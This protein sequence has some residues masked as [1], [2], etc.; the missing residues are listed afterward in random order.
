M[1]LA[2]PDFTL[3]YV[4]EHLTELP[5][6]PKVVQKALAMLED[7]NTL[8]TDLA[9]VL[10]FDPSITANILKVTNSAHFG[11][12][13][14][15]TSLETALALLG[16]KQIRE[17]LVA[18]ASLPYL[19][20]PIRGYGMEPRDLWAHSI[21]CALAS[22]M[23]AEYINFP[24]TDVLFTSALLH[25]IGKIVLNIFV[26]ARLDEIQAV[27]RQEDITFS[28][29]EW[30]VIG[31]DHAVLGSQLL[32]YWELPPDIVRAVRNHHDP[33]LYVQDELSALLALSNILAVKLGIGVGAD[34]F[35]HRINPRLLEMLGLDTDDCLKC[36]IK[37]F[38]ALNEAQDL[39]GLASNL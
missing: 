6:F 34:A 18:S 20:R 13:Q 21:G 27:A 33:D 25:D 1:T 8:I 19:A 35:R 5:T 24:A 16:Q 26:G 36:M 28:E 2:Q 11:L 30:K 31:S 17:V 22:E 29:A 15:V 4:F 39:L 38:E 23:L 3:E 7:P 14:Q 32:R 10:K 9:E 37:S 12:P